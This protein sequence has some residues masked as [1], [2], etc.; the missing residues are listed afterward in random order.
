MD[1]GCHHPCAMMP[2]IPLSHN[3]DEGDKAE[4]AAAATSLTATT[5]FT[6]VTD[7]DAPLALPIHR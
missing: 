5:T 6:F 1:A 7:E 2:S 3:K 4:V